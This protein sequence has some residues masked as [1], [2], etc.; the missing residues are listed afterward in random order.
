[1]TIRAI[2]TKYTPEP[3]GFDIE[4]SKGYNTQIDGGFSI[5]YDELT[6]NAID[7][8]GD[9]K[10]LDKEDAQAVYAFAQVDFHPK[11]EQSDNTSH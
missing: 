1:M 2:L 4:V 3:C 10:P 9:V 5:H 11:E 6:V 8:N 7:M